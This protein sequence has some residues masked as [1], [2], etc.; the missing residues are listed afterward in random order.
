[1]SRA[2]WTGIGDSCRDDGA[3][4]SA[5][6]LAVSSCIGFPC[7]LLFRG[8]REM[9]WLPVVGA[10]VFGSVVLSAILCCLCQIKQQDSSA[11]K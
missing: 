7:T 3:Y 2:L 11:Q 6:A 8:T 10:A 9:P 1:M 5:I 4:G